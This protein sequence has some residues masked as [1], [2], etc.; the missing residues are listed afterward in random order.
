MKT[1]SKTIKK[2]DVIVALAIEPLHSGLWIQQEGCEVCA[3]GAVIRRTIA[4]SEKAGP[5]TW[6]ESA[7]ES[8]CS[9]VTSANVCSGNPAKLIEQEDYLTALS[10]FFERRVG[11][12]GLASPA[13]RAAC[14]EFVYKNFPE[15][16]TIR[17]KA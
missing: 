13:D 5:G 17:Y 6:G 1:K 7:M 14:L 3:V 11:E 12:D 4:P 10:A 15:K 2:L 9:S 16:F 8:I